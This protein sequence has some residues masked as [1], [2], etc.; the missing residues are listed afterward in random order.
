MSPLEPDQPVR[1]LLAYPPLD[2]SK[3]EIRLITLHPPLKDDSSLRCTFSHTSLS[4]GTGTALKLPSYGTLSYVWGEP[5]FSDSI[6]VYN[7]QLLVT[8]NL[9]SILCNFR[10]KEKPR[11]FWIDAFCINQQDLYER[12]QQVELIRKVYSSCRRVLAWVGPTQMDIRGVPFEHLNLETEHWRTQEEHLQRLEKGEL[13]HLKEQ[14]QQFNIL[15][16]WWWQRW[17]YCER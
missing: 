6:I 11:L 10:Q 12:A 4:F 17:N 16:E 2:P 13:D 9:T 1:R 15:K 14:Q 3:E 7:Q 5:D 8:H